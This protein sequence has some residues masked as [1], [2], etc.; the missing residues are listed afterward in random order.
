MADQRWTEAD[1]QAYLARQGMHN[2]AF[3]PPSR[4]QEALTWPAEGGDTPGLATAPVRGLSRDICED[5]F[6]T[7]IRRIA[8]Q[9]GWACYH[10][11][12]SKRS[13]PGFP[14]LVL[15][16]GQSILFVEAKTNV[17]KLTKDQQAWLSLLEHTGLV[18]VHIWRPKDW[19]AIVARLTQKRGHNES[20]I[21]LS[22]LYSL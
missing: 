15:C 10:T 18:E 14:D 4:A 11:Y 12:C 9:H 21:D 2:A 6:L 20:R 17:G 19:P 22:A 5:D 7:H 16:N 8:R 3:L 13:E 1:V